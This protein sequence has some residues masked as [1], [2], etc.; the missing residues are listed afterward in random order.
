MQKVEV[1]I[2]VLGQ[3]KQIPADHSYFLYSALNK[4][5]PELHH[6]KEP[7]AKDTLISDITGTLAG[8]RKK[9]ISDSSHIRIR[10]PVSHITKFF[11]LT[12][13]TFKIGNTVLMFGAP[14]VKEIRPC[15]KAYSRLVIIGGC[16]EPKSFLE[17]ANKQLNTL[18]I[19]GVLQIVKRSNALS[20]DTQRELDGREML[21]RTI[22]IHN[23]KVVG[24]AVEVDNMNEEDSVKLL[25]T[26]IGGRHKF[27]CGLFIPR[28]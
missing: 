27:G 12:G 28:D 13:K 5:L 22:T 8:E 20:V 9:E 14:D 21:R 6:E 24:Y 19:Q 26:G 25:S 1:I 2:P 11:C 18:D 16:E 7:L 23:F 10:T 17:S 3:G 4:F 15:K